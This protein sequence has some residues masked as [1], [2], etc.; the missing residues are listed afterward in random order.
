MA[1]VLLKY[2]FEVESTT[3]ISE[4]IIRGSNIPEQL[5]PK[6]F[7]IIPEARERFLFRKLQEPILAETIKNT[8]WNFIRFSDLEKVVKAARK[9]FDPSRLD[10]VAR[11]PKGG[12]KQL[13]LK[14]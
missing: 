12:E 7:I 2:E 8:R 10:A 9:T 5:N 4:A 6:R 14:L 3:G 1:K 11:M 13:F